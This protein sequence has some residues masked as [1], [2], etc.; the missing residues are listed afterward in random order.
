MDSETKVGVNTPKLELNRT[1]QQ[2]SLSWRYGHEKKC[3][4]ILS[5]HVS[6]R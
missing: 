3:G 6:L 2:T 5:L 1:L 4:T